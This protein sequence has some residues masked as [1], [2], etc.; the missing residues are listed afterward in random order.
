[1]KWP[2]IWSDPDEG[3]EHICVLVRLDQY[4]DG[5]MCLPMPL[6]ETGAIVNEPMLAKEEVE[7]VAWRW[8]EV[9]T[10]LHMHEQKRTALATKRGQDSYQSPAVLGSKQ[11]CNEKRGSPMTE[12]ATATNLDQASSDNPGT[13]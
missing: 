11:E 6:G 4:G 8:E 3:I 9:R 1:M 5:S 13:T 10:A 12:Q 2:V 7:C